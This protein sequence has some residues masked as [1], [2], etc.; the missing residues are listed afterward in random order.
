MVVADA[1]VDRR[2]VPSRSCRRRR[3][4]RTCVR[5]VPLPSRNTCAIDVVGDSAR[6]ARMPLPGHSVPVVAFTRRQP[7]PYF[8]SCDAPRP[9]RNEL[10]S[11]L[12]LICGRTFELCTVEP[13]D[14]AGDQVAAGRQPHAAFGRQEEAGVVVGVLRRQEHVRPDDAVVG[15]LEEPVQRVVGVG[16]VL[17]ERRG[18]RVEGDAR[19]AGA[20][21]VLDLEAVEVEEA[22]HVLRRRLPVHLQVRVLAAASGRPGCRCAARAARP[23]SSTSRRTRPCRAPAVR[24]ASTP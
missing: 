6:R 23:A 24:R 19:R 21:V 10:R 16:V 9:F 13:Y 2:A 15:D 22:D 3:R 1:E 18:R 7:K 20:A 14:R 8:T 11:R 4:P 5:L 17:V 12:T